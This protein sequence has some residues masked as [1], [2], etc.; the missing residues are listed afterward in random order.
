MKLLDRIFATPEAIEKTVD[1]AISAGDKIWYTEEEKADDR[2]ALREWYL[3]YLEATAGHNLARRLIA[4]IVTGVWAMMVAVALFAYPFSKEWA[5][6][7]V[8]VMSALVADPYNL[9]IVFY[10]GKHVVDSFRKPPN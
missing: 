9:V 7:A 5:K 6:H 8:D 3:R 10:F 4:M 1:A 2:K